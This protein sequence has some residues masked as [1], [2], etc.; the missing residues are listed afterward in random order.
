MTD[1]IDTIHLTLPSNFN[2]IELESILEKVTEYYSVISLDQSYEELTSIVLRVNIKNL[3][4]MENLK[5]TIF[6]KFPGSSFS[7]YNSVTS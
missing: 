6:K 3:R 2:L 7:F 4:D 5:N 1:E